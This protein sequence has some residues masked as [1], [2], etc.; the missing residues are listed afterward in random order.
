VCPLEE[1]PELGDLFIKYMNFDVWTLQSRL[2]NS[3]K[4]CHGSYTSAL[5]PRV[6]FTHFTSREVP[7]LL[8]TRLYVYAESIVCHLICFHHHAQMSP[9]SCTSAR[10]VYR[11]D[12][13]VSANRFHDRCS[14]QGQHKRD[15]LSVAWYFCY[16]SLISTYITSL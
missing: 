3:D 4:T 6:S 11:I 12:K 9:L 13:P 10:Q 5:R 1:A 16:V 14:D 2:T 7:L 8:T 15:I